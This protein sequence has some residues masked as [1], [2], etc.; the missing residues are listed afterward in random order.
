[1][2]R[3]AFFNFFDDPPPP[4]VDQLAIDQGQGLANQK[5]ELEYYLQT[6][7]EYP[8]VPSPGYSP[9]FYLPNTEEDENFDSKRPA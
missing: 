1:M 7:V 4:P 8:R 2:L 9:F 3:L 6:R 5:Y